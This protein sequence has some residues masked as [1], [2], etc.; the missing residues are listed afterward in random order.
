[1]VETTRNLRGTFS[2]G[3]VVGVLNPKT[4]LFFLAFFPQ[5]CERRERQRGAC[6][7]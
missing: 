2:Q 6:N 3:V 5:F 1:V 4:A 7:S